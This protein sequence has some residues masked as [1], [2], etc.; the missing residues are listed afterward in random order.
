MRADVAR[1]A[2]A[3]EVWMNR[4]TSGR[5]LSRPLGR[6]SVG[7]R[8]ANVMVSRQ[9]PDSDV[10]AGSG[11]DGAVRLRGGMDGAVLATPS[12]AGPNTME[13]WRDGAVGEGEGGRAEGA[14]RCADGGL[15][16]RSCHLLDRGPS[17]LRLGIRG[18]VL[19]PGTAQGLPTGSA[20]QDGR[21][22]CAL[23]GLPRR[24]QH[25]RFRGEHEKANLAV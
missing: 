12:P 10:V 8:H 13:H 3:S 15:R 7:V 25:G 19:R 23:Q 14:R 20:P 4:H 1:D 9:A 22:C 6:D 18:R 11:M 21:V 24:H 16:G 5:A 17:P 2:T